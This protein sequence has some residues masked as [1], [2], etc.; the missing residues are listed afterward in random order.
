MAIFGGCFLIIL[1]IYLINKYLND[2]KYY[3]PDD[4]FLKKDKNG[5]IVLG[6]KKF[7]FDMSDESLVRNSPTTSTDYQ[8]FYPKDSRGK[9]VRK[10]VAKRVQNYLKY[11]KHRIINN[12]REIEN[13]EKVYRN[14]RFAN[15]VDYETDKKFNRKYLLII[16]LSIFILVFVI[17]S[18][19]IYDV[20]PDNR[21]IASSVLII[22]LGI[23][24]FILGAFVATNPYFQNSEDFEIHE[25]QDGNRKIINIRYKDYEFE[26]FDRF[27]IKHLKNVEKNDKHV[28]IIN[29][30]KIK[31]YYKYALLNILNKPMDLKNIE[32]YKSAR[33]ATDDEILEYREIL[34]KRR[35]TNIWKDVPVFLQ[36]LIFSFIFSFVVI[37]IGLISKTNTLSMV[38]GIF[39]FY[40]FVSFIYLCFGYY[41]SIDLY[42]SKKRKK[43]KK[44]LK[45]LEKG[46]IFI[47]E[48]KV[49]LHK[50]R[51]IRQ[52]G[53]QLSRRQKA[54]KFTVFVDEEGNYINE[55]FC[56]GVEYNSSGLDFQEFPRYTTATEKF[57]VI[58]YN[59][60]I[61]VDRKMG[62]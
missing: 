61:I 42:K 17:G 23:I 51:H 6:Y 8:N 36:G 37:I 27:D 15:S 5:K 10:V 54:T 44:I 31:R 38:F 53:G 24:E 13:K 60:E 49:L 43:V 7:I 50:I 16:I 19:F 48:V 32:L 18:Y 56:D 11:Y 28:S 34:E 1:L 58:K 4:F 59:D 55:W 52:T 25:M 62:L 9:T 12:L 29:R 35:K 33:R 41:N 45:L 26:L 20:L 39:V 14:E 40:L 46:Q 30:Y 3:N 21:K 57:F 22:G 47:V 2:P